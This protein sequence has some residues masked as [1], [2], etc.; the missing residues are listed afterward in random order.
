MPTLTW[1]LSPPPPKWRTTDI[2]KNIGNSMTE[3]EY[4][5]FRTPKLEEQLSA[6]RKAR[7]RMLTSPKRRWRYNFFWLNRR[8]LTPVEVY[9]RLHPVYPLPSFSCLWE[10]NMSEWAM[11]HGFVWLIHTLEFKFDFIRFHVR[12][13]IGTWKE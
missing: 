4:I 9:E 2:G 8:K 11:Q 10:R 5:Y 1:W 6:E 3:E 13:R 7:M 12:L